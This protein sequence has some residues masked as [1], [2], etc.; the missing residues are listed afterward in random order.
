MSQPKHAGGRPPLPQAA[1]RKNWNITL[2]DGERTAIEIAAARAGQAPR[3][4]ARQALLEKAE[5]WHVP[6]HEPGDPDPF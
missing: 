2:S 6:P 4:W 3:V 1:K 5:G